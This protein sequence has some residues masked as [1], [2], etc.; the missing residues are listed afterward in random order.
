MKDT[1][2][3][4]SGKVSELIAFNIGEQQ[5]CLCT[6]SVREIRG[7]TPSA[8]EKVATEGRPRTIYLYEIG[9]KK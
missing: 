6:T 2:V 8:V 9:S 7:W 3:N 1:T 5:F 4:R